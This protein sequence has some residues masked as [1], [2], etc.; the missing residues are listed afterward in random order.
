MSYQS[1]PIDIFLERLED[2]PDIEAEQEINL[3]K[4]GFA[5]EQSMLQ[6]E[7]HKIDA[8][9]S[10]TERKIEIGRAIQIIAQDNIRLNAKLKIVRER[11]W[12]RGWGK[13]VMAVCGPELYAQCREWMAAQK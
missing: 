13:A 4:E 1:L 2:M 9:K 6:T 10:K 11:I 12:N 8:Q 7:L 3:R 5:L